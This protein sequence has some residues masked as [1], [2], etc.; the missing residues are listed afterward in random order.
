MFPAVSALINDSQESLFRMID[1][2]SDQAWLNMTKE[3]YNLTI[4]IKILA[5]I[6][7]IMQHGYSL[8][9][10]AYTMVDA[11]ILQYAT[12]VTFSLFILYFPVSFLNIVIR[13]YS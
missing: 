13:H 9:T 12:V 8:L 7:F 11:I 6:G 4:N 10:S 3:S 5:K 1:S 2:V